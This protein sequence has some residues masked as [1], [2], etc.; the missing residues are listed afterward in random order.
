MVDF[1]KDVSTGCAGFTFNLPS[2][3]IDIGIGPDSL[4]ASLFFG[5]RM[6]FAPLSHV[7]S[8]TSPAISLSVSISNPRGTIATGP[9]S[10]RN[11]ISQ[12]KL[13]VN[14]CPKD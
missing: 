1:S 3:D 10:H 2:S 12:N 11:I 13:G 9:F 5:R 6:S 8:M 4:F 7:S 14:K